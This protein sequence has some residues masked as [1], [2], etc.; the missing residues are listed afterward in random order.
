MLR[1]VNAYRRAI[2]SNNA[3]PLLTLRHLARETGA[4]WGYLRSIVERRLN[5]YSSIRRRKQDGTFREI[6]APNPSL[7]HVQRWILSNV[8]VGL[9]FHDAAFAYR[10]GLSI[11]HCAEEHLGAKWLLKM[12]LHN[13]FGSIEE[14][15]AYGVLVRLGYPTLL[16]FEMAR[17]CTKPIALPSMTKPPLSG[18]G[19]HAYNNSNRGVLPQGAPT[20]GALANATAF[21]LDTMLASIADERGLAYTRYSDD[22]TFSSSEGLSR[23]AVSKVILQIEHAIRSSGFVVHKGKT[24][25]VTPG[26]RQIVLGLMLT[27]DAVRLVPEFRHQLDNHIRCVERYGPSA[28]AMTRRFDSALSMINYVDGCLAFATDIEPDWTAR[29]QIRWRAALGQHGHPVIRDQ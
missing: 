26:A 27:R 25:V 8:L 16:A 2:A 10:R 9:E 11:K 21:R 4:E 28:H 5:E 23:T 7:M 24:R 20:S 17:I 15:R 12:D 22:L 1:R 13:F 3:Y 19:L 6:S 29:R 18:R 14:S